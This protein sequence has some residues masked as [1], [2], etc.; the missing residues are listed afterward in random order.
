MC[1]YCNAY[2]IYNINLSLILYLIFISICTMLIIMFL[3]TVE[4]GY[5]EDAQFGIRLETAIAVTSVETKVFSTLF[6]ICI[7]E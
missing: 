2:D 5:Y 4:P 6:Y 3:S 7:L 1:Q